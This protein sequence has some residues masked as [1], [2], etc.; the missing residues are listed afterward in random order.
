[1]THRGPF[2]PLPFCDFVTWKRGLIIALNL[3][4]SFLL[5]KSGSTIVRAAAKAKVNCGPYATDT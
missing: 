2:Q 1:M 3:I 5:Q 4:Q